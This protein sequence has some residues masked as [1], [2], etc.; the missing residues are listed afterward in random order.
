MTLTGFIRSSKLGFTNFIRNYWLS[1]AATLVVT[2]MLFTMSVFAV[3]SVVIYR[4]TETL[5]QKINLEIFFSDSATDDQIQTLR[6]VLA[7]RIDVKSVTYIS[8]EQAYQI[9]NQRNTSDQI[10]SLVTPED[11]PLP[12]SIE[13]QAT[14][15]SKLADISAF[16]DSNDYQTLILSKSDQDSSQQRLIQNLAT[17]AQTTRRNGLF[18]SAIFFFIATLMVFNTARIVIHAREDEIEIMR[19]VGSTE[20]F[21]QWPFVLEGILYGIIGALLASGLLYVFLANDLLNST[22]LSSITGLLGGDMFQFFQQYFWIIIVIQALTGV[23]VSIAATS[24]AIYR[25]V[26]L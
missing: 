17:T 1:L 21:I 8:K 12:R 9:F 3:Q 6:Q 22:P 20:G 16:L 13:I 25:R 24:A 4:T 15:P 5:K 23:I 10:K 7:N 19:L 18:L 2:L 11:N 26:R 14:D